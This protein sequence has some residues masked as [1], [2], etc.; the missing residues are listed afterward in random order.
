MTSLLLLLPIFSEAFYGSAFELSNHHR[1]HLQQQHQRHH[2]IFGV[3]NHNDQPS[4]ST[5]PATT[6][7]T[8]D[9]PSPHEL[10]EQARQLRQQI[11]DTTTRSPAAPTIHPWNVVVP[12]DAPAVRGYRLYLD[13]GRE[14]HTWMDP[15][16]GQS[17]RRITGSL[18]IALASTLCYVAPQ[19]R[20][21]SGFDA[22]V[23]SGNDGNTTTTTT[24]SIDE[25]GMLRLGIDMGEVGVVDGDVSIP[26]GVLYFA[27]PTFQKGRILSTKEGFLTVRQ[28]GWHTGW[29]RL[30]RRM[31]GTFRAR[32][33][34]EATRIDGY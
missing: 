1:I 10:L 22:L 28:Y 20:L 29:W 32:P 8:T 7:T 13:I 11:D 31:V 19:L 27:L 9:E 6:T 21:R 30:E 16:W 24:Y 18:D 15:R 2:A 14:P 17:G 26:P 33:I 25:Q 34:E 4:S 3:H 12:P 5:T 23:L